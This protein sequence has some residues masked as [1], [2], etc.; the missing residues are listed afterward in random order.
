LKIIEPASNMIHDVDI[1]TYS[2]FWVVG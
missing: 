1:K 2:V